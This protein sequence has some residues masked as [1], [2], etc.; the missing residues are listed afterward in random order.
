MVRVPLALLVATLL[1]AF[2]HDI[3]ATTAG[4]LT[5][6]TY[7]LPLRSIP[8]G[9]HRDEIEHSLIET[10]GKLL[11]HQRRLWLVLH[12]AAFGCALIALAAS[13]RTTAPPGTISSS[14]PGA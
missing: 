2:L 12:G 10:H 1:V 6:D 11:R 7:Y 13:F 8:V 14:L 9:A 3:G 4:A 5:A